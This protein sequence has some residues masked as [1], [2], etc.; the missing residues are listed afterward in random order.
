MGFPE[1]S[2]VKGEELHRHLRPH[3][4]VVFGRFALI[5]LYLAVVATV[6]ITLSS[7]GLG[8]AFAGVVTVAGLVLL[9]PFSIW[10]I[11]IWRS[12]HIAITNER[13]LQRDGVVHQR[14]RETQLRTLDRVGVDQSLLD[15][16]FNSGD[17][18]LDE[19]GDHR[20][21]RLPDVIKIEVLINE[22]I[23]ARGHQKGVDDK[24]LEEM[25]AKK[26]DEKNQAT[27]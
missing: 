5:F 4:R 18:V 11:I 10:P 21:V 13:I 20:L 24:V 22:L 16:I 23:R 3:W 6:W 27:T 1:N 19:R 8:K 25:I 12:T 17:L 15:R 9:I 2:L 26:A 7:T 14:K